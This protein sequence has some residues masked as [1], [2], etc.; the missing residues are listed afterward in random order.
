MVLGRPT[1][2]LRAV[3]NL[4]DY[5]HQVQ[6]VFQVI[7][8]RETTRETA[9]VLLSSGRGLSTEDARVEGIERA[10]N[11]EP[12]E[13]PPWEYIREHSWDR[14]AVQMLWEGFSDPEIAERLRVSPK[15]ITNRFS[16][17]RRQFPKRASAD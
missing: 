4:L 11:D 13:S 12:V 3:E 5:Y 2:L 15:R 1:R 10:A 17:L 9:R 8:D 14:T 6:S 16:A 7:D